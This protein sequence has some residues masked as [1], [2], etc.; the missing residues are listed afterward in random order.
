LSTRR[1]ELMSAQPAQGASTRWSTPQS[2]R[3]FSLRRCPEHCQVRTLQ[4]H[5]RLCSETVSVSSLADRRADVLTTGRVKGSSRVHASN[6]REMTAYNDGSPLASAAAGSRRFT[7]SGDGDNDSQSAAS[8]AGAA[9]VSS[10]RPKGAE[11]SAGASVHGQTASASAATPVVHGV[12]TGTGSVDA[13][14]AANVAD[15]KGRTPSAALRQAGAVATGDTQCEPHGIASAARD[16]S[17]TEVVPA[18]DT[19]LRTTSDA[20]TE[21]ARDVD[22]HHSPNPSTPLLQVRAFCVDSTRVRKSAHSCW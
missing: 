7:S 19:P 16:D 2:G 21:H 22:A 12:S 9:G 10:P 20:V 4:T 8:A 13:A 15:P 1:R 11:I 3:Q 17:P 18:P 6:T 14:H 5:C